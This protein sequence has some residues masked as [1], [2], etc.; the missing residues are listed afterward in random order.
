M[1]GFKKNKKIENHKGSNALKLCFLMLWVTINTHAHI[2][3]ANF[4]KGW[5]GGSEVVLELLD[6]DGY[7]YGRYYFVALKKDVFLN[8]TCDS[9]HC[10]FMASAWDTLQQAESV[11]EFLEIAENEQHHWVGHWRSPSG[12]IEPV[13]LKPFIKDTL[14]NQYGYQ[15]VID[16]FNAYSYFRLADLQFKTIQK[17]RLKN[18]K[19]IEWMIEP[20]SGIKGF[21]FVKGL[22][23]GKMQRINLLLEEQHLRDV[24]LFFG[25]GSVGHLGT[26]QQN[27]EITYSNHQWISYI[28]VVDKNCQGL[29]TTE[30][31]VYH[32]MDLDQ[33]K[34]LD[35]E[36]IFW[37]GEGDGVRKG[38]REYFQ[39]RQKTLAPLLMELMQSNHPKEFGT[40]GCTYNNNA[41][42][43]FPEW[44]LTK[45]GIRLVVDHYSL[46]GE[47]KN[48]GWTLLPYKRIKGYIREGYLE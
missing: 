12:E 39:Y 16:K 48:P 23:E 14:Y 25:C 43:A 27:I 36:D 44:Y 41:L 31:K 47:C 18:G 10:R 30:M 42:W 29:E 45:K 19:Q 5:F 11:H 15:P 21:R 38:S 3:K 1:P 24:E 37:A 34:L 2:E 9:T 13:Y 40:E 32:T 20:I 17:E 4:L 46:K 8:V 33:A 35:L 28:K 6:I 7:W 26:Y 22:D